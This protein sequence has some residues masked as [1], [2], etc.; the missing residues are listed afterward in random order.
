[1]SNAKSEEDTSTT[2]L[3]FV[4]SVIDEINGSMIAVRTMAGRKRFDIAKL[5]SISQ[6]NVTDDMATQASQYAFF[7]VLAVEA[8]RVFAMRSLLCDQAAATADETYR[9]EF[10]L[11]GN[12]YTEAVIKS[13]VIRD[14][15]YL[16]ALD[17]KMKAEY[18][19]DIL[20]AIVKAFEQRASMLQSLGSQLRYEYGMQGMNTKLV[21]DEQMVNTVKSAIGERRKLKKI[22]E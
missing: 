21:D 15:D 12:K 16:V 8:D 2:E 1:M 11:N 13:L 19:L 6:E 10:E 9:K 20:K 3:P 22:K 4:E 7:A 14:K 5:F 18:D 17:D